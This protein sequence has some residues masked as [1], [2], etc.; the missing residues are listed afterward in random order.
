MATT[1]YAVTL[2]KRN[3]EVCSALETPL[4][5]LADNLRYFGLFKST[6]LPFNALLIEPD[7]FEATVCQYVEDIGQGD[8]SVFEN[9]KSVR[10]VGLL[11][12]VLA[13]GSQLSALPLEERIDLSRD[14]GEWNRKDVSNV[15]LTKG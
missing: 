12:A 15:L 11:L 13:G 14:Y 3:I 1:T 9:E 7:G 8:L 6:A 10:W 2:G 4:T 5:P